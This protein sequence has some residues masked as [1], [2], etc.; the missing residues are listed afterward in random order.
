MFKILSDWM[1]PKDAYPGLYL[2]D[3]GD[4][5]IKTHWGEKSEIK[6]SQWINLEGTFGF[7]PSKVKRLEVDLSVLKNARMDV[8]TIAAVE[9]FKRSMN[10][11]VIPK[12]V[13]D[14]RER[15]KANQESRHWLV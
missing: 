14:M 1:N 10:E 4:V 8:E 12:I 15:Q 11:E 2:T 5:L 13:E 6:S 7:T 3:R 9:D